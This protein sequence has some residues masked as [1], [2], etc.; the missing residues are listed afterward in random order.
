MC[1]IAGI[2]ASRPLQSEERSA[3]DHLALLLKHRGPDAQGVFHAE[4]SLSL[5]G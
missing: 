1:G 4:N 2:I 5:G 3:A